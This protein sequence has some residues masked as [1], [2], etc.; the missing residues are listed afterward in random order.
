MT[1]IGHIDKGKHAEKVSE[2][3]NNQRDSFISFACGIL[4]EGVSSDLVREQ[5]VRKIKTHMKDIIF[6]HLK[7]TGTVRGSYRHMYNSSGYCY[8]TRREPQKSEVSDG[9]LNVVKI[10][11]TFNEVVNDIMV[12]AGKLRMV[13][14]IEAT[15]KKALE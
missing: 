11:P 8:R 7:R 10:I 13:S 4:S 5:L 14:A 6:E 1:H 9:L 15:T 12:E 3:L 2:L